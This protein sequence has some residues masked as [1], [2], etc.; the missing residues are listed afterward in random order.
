MNHRQRWITG[1]EKM[2][3]G[4][5]CGGDPLYPRAGGLRL[6]WEE[7]EGHRKGFDSTHTVAASTLMS[8]VHLEAGKDGRGCHSRETQKDQKA[9]TLWCVLIHVHAGDGEACFQVAGARLHPSL[10][11]CE[12]LLC[13]RLAFQP[14]YLQYEYLIIFWCHWWQYHIQLLW[15]FQTHGITGL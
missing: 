14:K 15:K 11:H 12:W 3:S 10:R 7:T 8:S 13:P 9:A 5:A 2:H 1:S 4:C 6:F